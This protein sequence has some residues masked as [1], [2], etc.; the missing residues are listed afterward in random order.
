MSARFIAF[1][2]FAI[3][4]SS[5]AGAQPATQPATQPARGDTLL[6]TGIIDAP[7]DEIFDCFKTSEGIVK[8]WGVAQ[9]KVDFRIGGQIRTAYAKDADL[10]SP[11]AIVNTI[12]SYV[13]GRMLAMKPTA[14]PRAPDWL[15]AICD[16]GWNVIPL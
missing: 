11:K 8:A 1:T 2:T 15:Q 14:P 6:V 4:V 13:P 9:A 5:F 10:D 3:L 12:L 16:T 7:R